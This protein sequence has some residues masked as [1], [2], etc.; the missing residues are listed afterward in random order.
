MS[1]VTFVKKARKDNA[2]CKKGESYYWWQFA[3]CAAQLSKLPPKPSQL[4]R[5]EF[6]STIY[7]LCER[8]E[9]C[10]VDTPE[11]VADFIEEV[12]DEIECLR[13]ETQDKLDNMPDQLQD[14]KTGQMMQERID[15]CDEMISSLED[16]DCDVD[17]D[18]IK[19]EVEGDP[20]WNKTDEDKEA[21]TAELLGEKA[22]ELV[23]ELQMISYDGA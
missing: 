3:Y 1:K 16:I 13:D 11:E 18:A 8:I 20:S 4:M 14:A 23:G 21:R 15:G 12:K 6:L 22:C 5:S 9:A 19:V 2:V 10:D 17:L 7:E